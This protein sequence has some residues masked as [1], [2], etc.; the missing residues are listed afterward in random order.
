MINILLEGYD[1]NA[2]WLCDE[3]KKYILPNYSVAVVAFSFRDNKVKSSADWHSLYNKENG[4]YYNAIVGGLV[5]YGISEA[6]VSFVNY[7]EDTK[8]SAKQKIERADIVYFLGGLPD[9]MMDRLKE[10]DLV[11]VLRKHSGIIMGYSA[12]AVIQLAEYHLSPD[13]DYKEFQYYDGLGY[14]DDF[15]L[16]VHYENTKVQN[17]AINRV[18]VE[19]HKTVYATALTSGAII[20]DNG[21]VKLLGDVKTFCK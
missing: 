1:I 4:K 16:E 10:F 21:N 15:Y 14:L 11:G 8:E 13:D 20:V 17:D 3:L 12:G 5:A 7:F 2:D 18:L 9:K 6:N 19:K